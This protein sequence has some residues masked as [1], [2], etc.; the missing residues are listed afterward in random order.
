MFATARAG[1]TW[2]PVPPPAIKKR[3]SDKA[4]STSLG[5]GA[6]PPE[7]QLMPRPLT[8]NIDVIRPLADARGSVSVLSRNR[9]GVS[10]GGGPPMMMTGWSSIEP[11]RSRDRHR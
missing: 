11:I 7:A 3:N 10:M 4:Q 9:K 6:S 2:P 1:N 5:L 8:L